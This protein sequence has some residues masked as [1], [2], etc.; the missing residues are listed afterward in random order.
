MNELCHI[1]TIL[2][3]SLNACRDESPDSLS[4]LLESWR[5]AVGPD[6]SENTRPAGIRKRLL[7][8]YVT[9]P[10]WIHHLHFSKQSIIE[11]LNDRME[12][13]QIADIRFR[14]GPV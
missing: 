2:Q 1:G 12:N 10:V 4:V 8:V 13:L 6:V 9:S 5:E 7:V 14:I 3:Q 11:R